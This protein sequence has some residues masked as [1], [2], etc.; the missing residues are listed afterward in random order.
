MSQQDIK[1]TQ[2]VHLAIIMDGNGRWAKAKGLPRLKGHEEGAKRVMEIAEEAKKL[3]ISFLS[4]FAFSTENWQRSTQEVQGLFRILE[5]FAKHYKQRLLDDHIRFVVSG[6]INA[7]P[8]STQ[9]V[10]ADLINSTQHETLHTLN[11]CLNYGGQ[12]EI[13]EAARRIA[14]AVEVGKLASS[15][16]T[17]QTIL[18]HSWLGPI[19]PPIDCLV[20]TSGE[21][22]LSNFMLLH[23]AYSELIFVP[24]HWP[25]FTREQLHAVLQEFTIRQRRYGKE[26]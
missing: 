19:L 26:S 20:R 3:G 14:K 16:L 8:A 1:P 23:L 2:P 9:R 4:L 22:R 13:L 24:I 7:L 18:N 11:V 10:V 15:D 25:D 12:Q 6:D 17:Y 21:Q 5:T